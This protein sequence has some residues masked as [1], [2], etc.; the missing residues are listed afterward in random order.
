[1]DW[2]Y[3][4]N[5]QQNGPVTIEALVSMLQQGHVQPSD[6]V[7]R[8]GMGNWQP[9][10]MVPELATVMPAPDPRWVISIRPSAPGGATDLRGVLASVRGLHSRLDSVDGRGAV[11]N[12]ALGLERPMFALT[13]ACRGRH[14]IW[15][16]CPCRASWDGSP[17]G[18]IIR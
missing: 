18:F 17:G 12:L 14:S 2:F 15:A 10:G 6:L 13:A 1:M 11:L 4:K 8:E 9:A 7:W 5:N 16:W 3:A